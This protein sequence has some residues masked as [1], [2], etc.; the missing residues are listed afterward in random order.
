[1]ARDLPTQSENMKM[2]IMGVSVLMAFVMRNLPV[3]VFFTFFFNT[4]FGILQAL[5]FQRKDV[6]KY[7]NVPEKVVHEDGMRLSSQRHFGI[8]G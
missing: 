3:A 1:M 8:L 6:K 2:G 5:I 7:F 4:S